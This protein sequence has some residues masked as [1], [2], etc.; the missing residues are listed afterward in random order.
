MPSAENRNFSLA[1]SHA[2]FLTAFRLSEDRRLRFV[3]RDLYNERD[4]R[5]RGSLSMQMLRGL[6]NIVSVMVFARGLAR[7]N[8]SLTC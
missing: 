3:T 6:K 1:T 8:L 7:T 5:D 4:E 2:H